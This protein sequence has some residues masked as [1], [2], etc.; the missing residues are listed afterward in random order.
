MVA[1]AGSLS[2]SVLTG[3]CRYLAVVV[4][5]TWCVPRPMLVVCIPG[6]TT[7]PPPHTSL[8]CP[9]PTSLSLVTTT[10]EAQPVQTQQLS[11]SRLA[12]TWGNQQQ[13]S[14]P[15]GKGQSSD[16]LMTTQ[17]RTITLMIS[18]HHYLISDDSQCSGLV[19]GRAR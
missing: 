14:S 5:P 17:V 11:A 12:P 8:A 6:H 1:V 18:R 15:P 4:L 19:A 10:L 9:L 13:Q 7:P 3:T 2:S 16:Y